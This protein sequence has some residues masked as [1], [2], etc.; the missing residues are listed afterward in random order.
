MTTSKIGKAA[1]GIILATGYGVAAR[2]RRPVHLG[3]I[4]CLP[5]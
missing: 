4:S 1:L 5:S 3:P 2:R